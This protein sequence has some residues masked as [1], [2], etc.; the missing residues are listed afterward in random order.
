MR[1]KLHVFVAFSIFLTGQLSLPSYAEQAF[2]PPSAIDVAGSGTGTSTTT[3]TVPESVM[4]GLNS[5]STLSGMNIIDFGTLAGGHLD[6]GN[7]NF[8]NAAGGTIYAISSNSAIQTAQISA[9]NIFNAGT[10]TTI[11]PTGGLPGYSTAN[12]VQGLNLSLSAVQNIVNTGSLTS[13][14]SL[15]VSAPAVY[16]ALPAATAASVAPIMSAV[17]SLNV[18]TNNLI[19]S[20]TIV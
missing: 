14:G 8:A 13:A 6:F 4:N 10:I 15:A 18:Q 19:N 7:N 17:Q 20:G 11:I 12:L 16:N 3:P 1:K 9:L 5:A 2:T